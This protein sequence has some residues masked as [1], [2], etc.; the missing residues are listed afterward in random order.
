MSELENIENVEEVEVTPTDNTTND[1]QEQSTGEVSGEV[2]GEVTEPEDNSAEIEA[3]QERLR[4]EHEEY[5]NSFPDT[6]VFYRD[7]LVDG[8]IISLGTA[9]KDPRVADNYGFL[10]QHYDESQL[11]YIGTADCGTYYL[12][13]YEKPEPLLEEL[14]AQKFA[15]ISAEAHKYSQYECENMY[16]T[17]SKGFRINADRKAQDNLKGLIGIGLTCKFKDYDNEFHSGTTVEDLNVMLLECYQNGALMYQ[18]KF[19]YEA[20]VVNAQSKD[21]LNFD[22]VF[23]MADFSG[24]N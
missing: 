7:L 3:E 9:V 2:S 1:L 17:S 16:L 11:T 24:N 19:D 21:D 13:G 5:L 6:T 18:K 23:E 10:D 12:K 20:Q 4:R 22:V 15:Q 8:D 14:K